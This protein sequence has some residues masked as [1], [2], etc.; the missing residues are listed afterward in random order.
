MQYASSA[1]FAGWL[2][3]RIADADVVHGPVVAT[4]VEGLP[5]TL[6]DC[7]GVLVPS[8]DPDALAAAIEGVLSGH[9]TPDFAAGQRYAARFSAARVASYYMAVYRELVTGLRS[10]PPSTRLEARRRAA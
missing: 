4:N 2:A 10:A 1:A 3:P 7:R 5:T 9:W 6:A 8:E